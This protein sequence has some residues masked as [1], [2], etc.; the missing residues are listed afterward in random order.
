MKRLRFGVLLA[1]TFSHIAS[2]QQITRQADRN[3][4]FSGFH[5]FKW[6]AIEGGSQVIQITASNIQ[7]A[8]NAE[9]DTKG[10]IL[11]AGDQPA[12]LRLRRW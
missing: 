3:V 7:S 6:V 5:T 12:G 4:D 9:L 8:V 1:L 2:A 10:M 11:V